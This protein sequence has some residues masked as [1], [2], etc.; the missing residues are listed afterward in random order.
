MVGFGSESVSCDRE[1]LRLSKLDGWKSH[2]RVRLFACF[3]DMVEH[4]ARMPPAGGHPRFGDHVVAGRSPGCVL[5]SCACLSSADLRSDNAAGDNDFNAP[6]CLAAFCRVVVGYRVAWAI[7][8]CREFARVKALG[9]EEIEHS[10]GALLG[11]A[12]D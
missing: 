7:T 1:R 2:N 3:Y 6:V 5:V 12:S 4:K 11:V 10:L 9:N 8:L